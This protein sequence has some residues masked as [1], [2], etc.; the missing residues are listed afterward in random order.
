VHVNADEPDVLDF[1]TSFK[2]SAVDAIYAPDQYRASDHDAA[3][4]GIHP[5]RSR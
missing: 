5:R 2:P 4:V 1:D 3:L